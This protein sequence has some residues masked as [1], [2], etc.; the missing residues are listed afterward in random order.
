M[1]EFIEDENITG[2]DEEVAS[3]MLRTLLDDILRGFPSREA[4]ILPLRY[5]LADG[6]MHTFEDVGSKLGVTRERVRQIEP[7]AL[8]RLRH[9]AYYSRRLR[10]FLGK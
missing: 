8:R 6:K 1:G 2:P 4:H 9:P 5:G 10:D 3:G 7:R